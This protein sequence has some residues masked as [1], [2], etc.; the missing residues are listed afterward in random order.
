MIKDIKNE[1]AQDITKQNFIVSTNTH[2][3]NGIGLY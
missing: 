2:F 3:A 1:N